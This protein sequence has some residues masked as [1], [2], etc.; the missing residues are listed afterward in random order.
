MTVTKHI[1]RVE[2]PAKK[3]LDSFIRKGRKTAPS[4]DL[5]WNSEA[6]PV[7]REG[8]TLLG[9]ISLHF[10]GLPTAKGKNDGAPFTEPFASFARATMVLKMSQGD[11]TSH[12]FEN[13]LKPLRVLGHLSSDPTEFGSDTFDEALNFIR[14]YYAPSTHG[15]MAHHLGAIAKVM[16]EYRL[17]IRPLD[18]QNPVKQ[19]GKEHYFEDP[20]AESK[21]QSKMP[22]RFIFKALA[23]I[24]RELT[25]DR[26]RLLMALTKILF[27]TGLRITE[28]LSLP[29]DTLQTRLAERRDGKGFEL[30]EDGNPVVLFRLKL[31]GEK[32]GHRVS[33]EKWLPRVAGKFV[34][35]AV[36]EVQRITDPFRANAEFMWENP[37]RAKL[38][39]SPRKQWFGA[40]EAGK[41]L[42]VS[43]EKGSVYP[44]LRKRGVRFSGNGHNPGEVHR[45]DLEKVVRDE[46]RLGPLRVKPWRL[47]LHR[48]LFVVGRYFFGAKYST[49][50]GTALPVQKTDLQRWLCGSNSEWANRPSIFERFNK[51]DEHG[52]P[53]RTTSHQFRHFLNTLLKRAGMNEVEVAHWFNR[54]NPDHTKH[55]DW[56]TPIEK[57]DQLRD[58][59]RQ[60]KIKGQ[61]GDL[62]K[63][64]KPA[65]RE[66]FLEA[67]LQNVHSSPLGYCIHDYATLPKEEPRECAVCPGLLVPVGEPRAKANA[68][69]QYKETKWLVDRALEELG[70]GTFGADNWLEFN[71]RKLD[72]LRKVVDLHNGPATEGVKMVQVTPAGSGG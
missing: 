53:L 52:H 12:A 38:Q 51:L 10:R 22:H 20:E 65:E 28:A 32:G 43:T 9:R 64:M 62:A 58:L 57:A 8:A 40:I 33:G 60:G 46:S 49:I 41:A 25:E 35:E 72:A 17:T 6:W 34:A 2:H 5:D 23:E 27:C 47:E 24:D 1:T 26:D 70:D 42:G 15:S 68:E 59:A 37:G 14:G 3:N 54:A 50:H 4:L 39:A 69:Q 29:K 66:N 13:L 36:G 11:Y 16:D 71:M 61:L 30:E 7:N 21:L 67:T 44:L 56:S 31:A 63:R 45:S 19:Q 18:W 55:Y 48:S